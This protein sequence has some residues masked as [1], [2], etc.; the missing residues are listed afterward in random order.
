MRKKIGLFNE[1][2]GDEKLITS[3]LCIMKRKRCDYTNT[4]R[5]LCFNVIN[6][7]EE[8]EEWLLHWTERR[9]RQSQMIEESNNLMNSVNPAII[10]R[11]HIIE[12]IVST[13]S[14]NEVNFLL[15]MANPFESRE[16]DEYTTIKEMKGFKTHCNT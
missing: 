11:N 9:S 2:D 12:K 1:E 13:C 15:A 16:K 5:N 6:A 3:L 8:C 10:P 14:E 4:F 7:D